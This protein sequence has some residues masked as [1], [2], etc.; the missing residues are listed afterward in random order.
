[1]LMYSTTMRRLAGATA[2]LSASLLAGPARA[3]TPTWQW[4]LQT[5][6]PTPT[7]RSE[8]QGN[9]VA[10]DASGRVYVGG[11]YGSGNSGLI[12]YSRQF[13]AAGSVTAPAGGFV[14][15]ASAVGQWAWVTNAVATGV[16]NTGG[17]ATDITAV[18]VTPTGEVYAAGTAQGTSLQ[19]GSRTAALPGSGQAVFVARLDAA[20]SCQ[21]LQI[22]EGIT[23]GIELAADPSTG[24]VVLAGLYEVPM[25]FGNNPLPAP[26][27]QLGSV[28][29][30]RLGAGG[31]WSFATNSTG[32]ANIGS[33]VQLAVGPAGQVAVGGAYLPGTLS[34]GAHSLT[35]ASS[36]SNA[37]FVAQLDATNQWQ[38]AVGGSGSTDSRTYD[39][40]YTP[41]GTVWAVGGGRTGTVVGSQTLT[42]GGGPNANN[43]AGFLGQLSAAGQWGTV[44]TFAATGDGLGALGL[45]S[46]DT[47]GLPVVMGALRGDNGPVTGQLGSQMLTSPNDDVLLFVAGLDAAGQW[48]YVTTVPQ[49]ALQDGINP[50][51]QALDRSGNLLLTGGLFGNITLGGTTLSGS[52]R[53]FVAT[54]DWGDVFLAKLTNVTIL[55]SRPSAAAA[56]APSCFPSPARGTATLRLPA[57]A[58]TAQPI[59]LLDA[60]GRAVRHYTVPARATETPLDLMGL[61][62]GLYVLRT[63]AATARL[64]VE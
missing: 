63:G 46:L 13:A 11:E 26:T 24:G 33:G 22:V 59:A 12:P 25:S 9:A 49:P 16:A 14:A 51:A 64:V 30:A 52:G 43:L 18:A 37:Y 17:T 10:T 53:S 45:L 23:S 58:A 34:F 31:Q 36:N 19:V 44:Q 21:G 1:M 60:L 40:A 38:W 2:L 7:D 47:N 15:Q 42:A 27:A 20:G 57:A 41:G 61:A 8:A 28:F 56:A 29:V 54:N 5:T 39:L 3:Q 62:P 55:G 4:A 48:R 32:A 6:N 50:K 35:I